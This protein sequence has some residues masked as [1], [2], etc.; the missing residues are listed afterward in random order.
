MIEARLT[1]P[2]DGAFALT[3][4]RFVASTLRILGADAATV[5]DV[6][7]AV[8]ELFAA[9]VGS[10]NSPVVSVRVPDGEG[11]ATV[12]FEGIPDPA[13][14]GPTTDEMEAFARRYRQQLLVSLFP[15]IETDARSVRIPVPIA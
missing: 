15:M 5:E 8:S 14:D 11:K 2:A 12:E 1:T 4:R 13:S 9:A 3:A 10:P 7:L 6:K